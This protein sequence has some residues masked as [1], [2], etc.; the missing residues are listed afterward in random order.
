MVCI[1]WGHC[2]RKYCIEETI[3]E[4]NVSE[5]GGDINDYHN[6]FGKQRDGMDLY[7]GSNWCP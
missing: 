7:Q 2:L 6:G 3:G 4:I 1:N 5:Q